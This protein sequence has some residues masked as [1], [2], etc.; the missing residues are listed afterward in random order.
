LNICKGVA[1]GGLPCWARVTL[2]YF[3]IF[4]L[5]P[6]FQKLQKYY[7]RVVHAKTV[8]SYYRPLYFPAYF[9]LK[10]SVRSATFSRQCFSCIIAH[11]LHFPRKVL[12][13]FLFYVM[14]FPAYSLC[15]LWPCQCDTRAHVHACFDRI[16]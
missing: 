7:F 12:S 10:Y 3:I 4:H 9:F 14:Y 1:N 6:S 11:Y 13:I 8:I 5:I 15:F 16:L 2:M